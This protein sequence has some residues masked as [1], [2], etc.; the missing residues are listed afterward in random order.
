MQN[1]E[2]YDFEMFSKAGNNACRSVVKKAINKINGTKR[3]T[4]DTFVEYIR[5][6]VSKVADKHGEVEDTEPTYHIAE[7][8][9][10]SLSEAGYAFSISRYNL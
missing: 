4:E 6:L 1:L 3:I 10:K 7:L 5:G 8:I 9:N 2:T